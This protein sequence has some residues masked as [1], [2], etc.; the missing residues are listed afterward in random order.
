L[1]RLLFLIPT[2][3]CVIFIVFLIMALI[4]GDPGR[5]QLGLEAPQ[6]AVDMFNREFGLDR[7]FLTRFFSYIGGIVT[8][9]DFG[10]SYRTR[11][12]VV[13]EIAGKLPVTFAVA[14]MSVAAAVLFGV[15]L[16]V[17]SAIKRSTL[18]D[19]GVT[20]L[21]LFFSAIPSFW[22]GLMLLQLFSITLAVL[23][24]HGVE[25]W[26]GYVLPVLALAVPGSS[27]FIRL[28]R[29]TML[30]VVHQE[31]INTARA[32]GASEYAVIWRHA[33][34][35]AALPLINGA[36]LMFGALLGGAVII[37]AVF[38]LP[39]LGRLL[40]TAISQRNMPI[41]MGCTI[42]MSA[43]FM[44]IILCIDIAYAALDPR[45]RRRFSGGEQSG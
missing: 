14:A 36:G 45:V 19:T 35:N 44:V 31:Y 10:V 4:P 12:P 6:E 13:S 37:E 2:L 5:T 1:R 15:P 38:S 30:D 40:V 42:F 39:G 27:G 34:R 9:L 21:A 33:F 24:S 18:V 43:V 11:S 16:G 22:F 23:P 20:V 28:T 41:V 29:V 8:R 25:T 7:P 32:K 17:L 26:R 3:I